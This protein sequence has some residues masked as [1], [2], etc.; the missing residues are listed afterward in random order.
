MNIGILLNV[1]STKLK[2]DIKP[3]ISVCS[4]I[5]KFMI[6]QTKSH[7]KHKRRES[8]DKNAVAIVKN[9]LRLARLGNIGSQRGKQSRGNPMQ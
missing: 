1:D 5:I 4:R 9:V 2:R 6:N 8:D 7:K 3:G